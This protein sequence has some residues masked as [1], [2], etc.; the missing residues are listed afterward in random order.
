MLYLGPSVHVCTQNENFSRDPVPIPME[1]L[2]G[3]RESTD[4]STTK[5]HNGSRLNL[6]TAQLQAP[7]GAKQH[8][9]MVQTR[10]FQTMTGGGVLQAQ[11]VPRISRWRW[12][13]GSLMV[14]ACLKNGANNSLQRIHSTHSI[15]WM[16]RCT[17]PVKVLRR[18]EPVE[19]VCDFEGDRRVG[20]SECEPVWDGATDKVK[21]L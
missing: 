2:V 12:R 7:F 19:K 13:S 4:L 5:K 3:L 20:D 21:S 6:A 8:G 1:R 16:K 11:G 17:L 18:T 10:T 15:V 9:D 14:G